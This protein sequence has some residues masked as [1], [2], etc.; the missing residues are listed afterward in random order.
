M[1]G[2]SWRTL[3]TEF[4]QPDHET[5]A[6]RKFFKS[7]IN[8]KMSILREEC[9]SEYEQVYHTDDTLYSYA[10]KYVSDAA[11]ILELLPL[12][13][14]DDLARLVHAQ[15]EGAPMN[16][17]AAGFNECFRSKYQGNKDRRTVHVGVGTGGWPRKNKAKPLS[18]ITDYGEASSSTQEGSKSEVSVPA[19]SVAE[20]SAPEASVTASSVPVRQSFRPW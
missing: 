12:L 14:R 13:F 4:N 17:I 3:A 15:Y 20:A 11:P 2:K 5:Q 18:D 16:S 10:G 8:K 6:I 9:G 7:L 19:V 1:V